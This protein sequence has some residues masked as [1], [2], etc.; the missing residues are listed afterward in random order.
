MHTG[1]IIIVSMVTI[2]MI[3][4]TVSAFIKYHKKIKHSH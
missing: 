1:E 2:L 4:A 3:F